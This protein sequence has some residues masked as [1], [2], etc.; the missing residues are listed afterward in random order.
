MVLLGLSGE[1]ELLA[2]V[3][4]LGAVGADPVLFREPDIGGAATAAAVCHAD[5]KRLLRK[6]PL[7]R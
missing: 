3:S 2:A 1:S 5:A 6:L 4:E 7:V